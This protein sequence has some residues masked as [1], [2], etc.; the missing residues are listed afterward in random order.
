M[1]KRESSLTRGLGTEEE[2]DLLAARLSLRDALDQL[3]EEYD[4]ARQ[5]ARESLQ[6]LE[7]DR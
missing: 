2:T 3:P 7:A 4:R 5:L 6:L 1:S